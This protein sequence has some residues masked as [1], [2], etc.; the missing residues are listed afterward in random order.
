MSALN[1]KLEG[2]GE[3][4]VVSLRLPSNHAL[5]LVVEPFSVRDAA[6]WLTR[7]SILREEILQKSG[8]DAIEEERG[9]LSPPA[10]DAKKAE[11]LGDDAVLELGNFIA[12]HI[13]DWEVKR[14]VKSKD[15]VKVGKS[16]AVAEEDF[17]LVMDGKPTGEQIAKILNCNVRNLIVLSHRVYRSMTVEGDIDNLEK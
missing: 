3:R 9:R 8:A 4:R 14:P 7:T 2:E 15:G 10:A 11:A 16:G 5:Y 1:I 17:E 13:A 6:R 12:A